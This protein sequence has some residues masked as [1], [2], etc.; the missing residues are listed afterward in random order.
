MGSINYVS[1]ALAS[2]TPM[3][4]G[5]IYYHPKVFGTIWMKSLGLTE[6]DLQKGNMAIIFGVSLIMSFLLSFVLLNFNN[7]VG[8]EGEFDTFAHGAWH[9]MF[10]GV[11]VATPVL[12]TN[13][14]FER[15]N[16]KNLLINV[17][18]WLITLA[19]MGGIVDAMNHW[20]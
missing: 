11:L 14:L 20:G 10:I 8:Q 13:G 6:E 19:T 1:I 7:D 4:I 15:K 16:W 2:V 12:V 3:I 17:G 5:F 9:G 18:Y